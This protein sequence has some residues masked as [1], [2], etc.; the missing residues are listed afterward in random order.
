MALLREASPTFP[1]SGADIDPH[2]KGYL[3]IHEFQHKI[4]PPSSFFRP[5]HVFSN[6]FHILRSLLAQKYWIEIDYKMTSIIGQFY[7]LWCHFSTQKVA[8]QRHIYMQFQ[9]MFQ[10]HS[11]SKSGLKCMLARWWRWIWREKC[12]LCFS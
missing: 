4:S 10:H 9:A 3:Q 2:W 8:F 7:S 12:L 6:H 5:H 1:R 11:K